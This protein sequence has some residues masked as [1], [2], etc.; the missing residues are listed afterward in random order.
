[1]G[2]VVDQV[3]MGQIFSPRVLR[4]SLVSFIPPV[5]HYKEKRKKLIIFITGL[6]NKPKGCGASVASAAGPFT[7]KKREGEEQSDENF[8]RKE[9]VTGGWTQVTSFEF[10]TL[11]QILSDKYKED[12]MRVACSTHG[13]RKRAT[14]R[15]CGGV[16]WIYLTQDR[17]KRR[18]LVNTVRQGT[19]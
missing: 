15:V 12:E 8:G 17:D 18:T 3:A 11:R 16:E 19:D 7:T 10:C 5:L 9:E 1:V 4:F 14:W 6:H 13:K 2:F